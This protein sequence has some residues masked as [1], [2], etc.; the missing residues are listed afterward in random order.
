MENT[1]RDTE[2][3]AKVET[4][5]TNIKE[6]LLDIKGELKD[7]N[8]T[9]VPRMEIN[10]MLRS[11][12][13]ETKALKEEIKEKATKEEVRELRSN[14]NSGKQLLV[15]WAAVIVAIVA[16]ILPLVGK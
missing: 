9:Y 6:L 11:R 8:Q 10:E 4:D 5:L 7:F 15:A 12:D 3:M 1:N 14:Q 16:I 2:R 13:E